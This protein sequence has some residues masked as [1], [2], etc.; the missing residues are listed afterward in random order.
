VYSLSNYHFA[1]FAIP[2]GFV[3]AIVLMFFM[4]E[5]HAD[6]KPFKG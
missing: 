5:T 1:L 4:P 2:T 6:V 3:V